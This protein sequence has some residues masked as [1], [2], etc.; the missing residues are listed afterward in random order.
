MCQIDGIP[1]RF[2]VNRALLSALISGTPL[3]LQPMG[4]ILGCFFQKLLLEES[5]PKVVGRFCGLLRKVECF[6]G[7]L[8]LLAQTQFQLM[9][10]QR[11]QQSHVRT[12]FGHHGGVVSVKFQSSSSFSESPTV[13]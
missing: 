9:R 3:Y 10:S 13:L 11:G 2:Q 6:V 7:T 1:A 8:T 4:A 12:Q 5:V